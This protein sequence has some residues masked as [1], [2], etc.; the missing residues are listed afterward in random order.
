MVRNFNAR[1]MDWPFNNNNGVSSA[2]TKMIERPALF[3]DFNYGERTVN[4]IYD[5]FESAS[6][7]IDKYYADHNGIAFLIGQI[8][9]I[10]ALAAAI[11]GA[12]VA[13]RPS[14]FVKKSKNRTE[15]F[16]RPGDRLVFLEQIRAYRISPSLGRGLRG[17]YRLDLRL[18]EINH[19]GEDKL[20][21]LGL[22]SIGATKTL[23]STSK[24]DEIF[25]ASGRMMVIVGSPGSGKTTALTDLAHRLIEEA[26]TN[27]ERPIPVMFSL[28]RWANKSRDRTLAEWL[29]DD[30]RDIYRLGSD[31][32]S[33]IVAHGGILPMLD[34]LDEV[35]S[36]RRSG[37]VEAIIH[38]LENQDVRQIVVSS[39]IDEFFTCAGGQSLGRIVRI[40]P[41]NQQQLE[42]ALASETLESIRKLLHDAPEL[43]AL[44]TTPLWLNVLSSA[45]A[46]IQ[47][48]RKKQA[49]TDLLYSWYV[50]QALTASLKVG[51]LPIDGPTS[52]SFLR[53]V[54]WLARKMREHGQTQFALED[55][56]GSW[57]GDI[58][59]DS[60]HDHKRNK[61]LF[62]FLFGP[63]SS[64]RVEG[65]HRLLFGLA[66]GLCAW[67]VSGPAFA[68]LAS[69]LAAS[70]LEGRIESAEQLAFS[71]GAAARRIPICLLFGVTVGGA[72]A[73]DRGVVAGIWVA[74]IAMALEV[75]QAGLRPKSVG[76][77]SLPNARTVMSLRY[78]LQIMLA[79]IVVSS[80]ILAL[81]QFDPQLAADPAVANFTVF[82][83][84]I[85]AGEK[86][87][88]FVLHH[89]AMR[90]A[91][92]A[93][94]VAPLAYVRF[95]DEA[96][97]RLLLVRRG[98]T[99]EF[100]H[101]TLRDYMAKCCG[102]DAPGERNS[103][104]RG[105]AGSVVAN[106]TNGLT[107]SRFAWCANAWP[108][109][110]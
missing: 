55:L 62:R 15:V 57:L 82:A 48:N 46:S 16:V 92:S 67:F 43:K 58:G 81:P 68:L 84:I 25:Y 6:K 49:S 29:A 66:V 87:G 93:S 110:R 39:R 109:S 72:V 75:M 44:A 102:D 61:G 106:R 13:L 41:L 97:D 2:A 5:A 107:R 64:K 20:K 50:R 7:W 101:V 60:I 9:A 56:N 35:D 90:L 77:S 8:V 99:Y 69:L 4:G 42:S 59:R 33:T 21:L 83:A 26:V 14:L 63:K 28:A 24:I 73:L 22:S 18:S 104:H 85:F 108:V 94:G 70:R 47:W 100:M 91:L 105:S 40:E 98:G 103:G 1:A 10:M 95:L 71:W 19:K 79:G 3:E 80:T 23:T 74:L 89:Y 53:N 30:L 36:R 38:Y 12:L 52:I 31:L 45:A 54:G 51:R 65:F 88:W 76:A 34:G 27:P 86:G 37:C 11:P 17:S 78:A 96:V 32:A